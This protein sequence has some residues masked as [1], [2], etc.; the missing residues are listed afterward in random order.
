LGDSWQRF[1]LPK[2]VT[3][4]NFRSFPRSC[5]TIIDGMN[6]DPVGKF[7]VD[8]GKMPLVVDVSGRMEWGLID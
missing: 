1:G 2:G 6:L 4:G 7:S 5:D 3:T 8:A